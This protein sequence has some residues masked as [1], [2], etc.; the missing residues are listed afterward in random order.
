MKDRLRIVLACIFALF[1]SHSASHAQT[2]Q[3]YIKDSPPETV[4][5]IVENGKGEARIVFKWV[6]EKPAKPVNLNCKMTDAPGSFN[7]IS[8]K[9]MSFAWEATPPAKEP[10]CNLQATP[11]PGTI[12]TG[13]L[14]I[15]TRDFNDL[16]VPYTGY[17]VFSSDPSGMA[18]DTIKFELHKTPF[19]NIPLNVD[20]G[21]LSLPG[22]NFVPSF[23]NPLFPGVIYVILG[24]LYL[25]RKKINN[26][27]WLIVV[28]VVLIISFGLVIS[29]LGK[30]GPQYSSVYIDG[31]Q[32]TEGRNDQTPF[33]QK[34]YIG[35]LISEKS[36]WGKMYLEKNNGDYYLTFRDLPR[37]GEYNGKIAA[38]VLSTALVTVKVKV[39][40]WVLYF[41]ATVL[42]GVLATTLVAPFRTSSRALNRA[43]VVSGSV[44][45]L[46]VT[47]FTL[48]TDTWGTLLDYVKAF[49]AGAGI[50]LAA[51]PLLAFMYRGAQRLL[52]RTTQRA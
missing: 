24:I 7:T 43:L 52:K 39:A 9:N 17:L 40:D 45:A 41:V 26:N 31:L 29:W 38:N 11:E 6:G 21:T 23:L 1:V 18:P 44:L 49:A 28:S 30:P 50:N 36:G 35:T 2:Q 20:N 12:L 19:S 25:L 3:K 42:G 51:K 46:L 33:P 15:E 34:K 4:R 16:S 48:Y 5:I 10:T 27:K 32:L 8:A 37:S 14:T 13:R 47:H 22:T